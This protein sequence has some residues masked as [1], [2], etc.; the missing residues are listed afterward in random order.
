MITNF[1]N[2]EKKNDNRKC[3]LNSIFSNFNNILVPYEVN[4]HFDTENKK[5][6]NLQ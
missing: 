4:R 1:T 2:T 3:F 6:E 5:I